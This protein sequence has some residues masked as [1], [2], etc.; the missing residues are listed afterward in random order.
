MLARGAWNSRGRVSGV[1]G[2][3]PFSIV[4]TLRG[5]KIAVLEWFTDHDDAVAAARAA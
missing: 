5:G 4:F 3:M 1:S 2:A